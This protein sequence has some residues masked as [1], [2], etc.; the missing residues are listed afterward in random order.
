MPISFGKPS[1]SSKREE[2]TLK[3]SGRV[4]EALDF[5]PRC[6]G[7]QLINVEGKIREL[8]DISIVLK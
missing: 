2:R 4:P 6:D 7:G 8:L 5:S 1:L 3:H